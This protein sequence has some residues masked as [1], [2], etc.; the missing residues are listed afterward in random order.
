VHNTV[1]TGQQ[2]KVIVESPDGTRVVVVGVLDSVE[3]Q[4]DGIANVLVVHGEALTA[5]RPDTPR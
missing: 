4:A 3:V 5:L 1:A 2:I